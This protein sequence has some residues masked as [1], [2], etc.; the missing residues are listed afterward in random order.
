MLRLF[1]AASFV[2]ISL[3]TFSQTI[4]IAEARLLAEDT[5]VTVSG[6]VTNGSEL[7]LVR[8]F[9]DGTAGIAAFGPDLEDVLRGDSITITGALTEFFGLLE[10]VSISSILNHGPATLPIEPEVIS[11]D[12]LAENIE[13]ELVSIEL[14]SFS[15]GGAN[16]AGN[17]SYDFS[18]AN[19]TKSIYVREGHPLVGELVPVGPV[20]LT[21]LASQFS[22]SGFGGHQLILRDTSDIEN[23]NPINII[24]S[25]EISGQSNTGFTLSW[26]TDIESSSEA[27]FTDNIDGTEIEANQ[28]S[29]N[30]NSTNHTL[31]FTGLTPGE[32]YFVQ[33]F[34]VANGD[35]AFSNV[36]A[37]ATE[38]LSGNIDVYFNGSVNTSVAS[39]ES[40]E[41]I[42][43]NLRDT[44][45]AYIDRAQSSLDLAIYNTNNTEIVQAVNA[46]F[47]RGVEI[48]YIA[49]GQNANS[50]LGALLDEI[51][52]LVRQNS[53][54]SG[55]HNKF[56]LVD[57]ADEDS[58]YVLSGSTNFTDNNLSTDPN[59]LVIIQ[60]KAL[61]KSYRIEFNEMWGSNSP[62]SDPSASRFGE[63]KSNNTP[64]KFI[65]D[66]NPV[67]LYFSPSDGTNAAI[68]QALESADASIAF[69]LF[70]FTQNTLSDIIIEK[71][72]NDFIS[73]E[74]I[75]NDI[76]TNGSDFEEMVNQGV[77][78]IAHEIEFSLHHKYAIVDHDDFTSDPIVVTGSHNWSA[79]AGSV[80]DENTLVIH[81]AEIANQ[82]Y[83]EFT[84]RFGEV[85]STATRPEIELKLYPNPALDW[86][87]LEFEG[88]GNPATLSI[89]SLEGKVVDQLNIH[90]FNGS[91]GLVLDVSSLRAGIYLLQ[92]NEGNRTGMQ[93]L[94]ISK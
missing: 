19:G 78:V 51:P 73:V 55:M 58:S 62:V 34:S 17:E 10:I 4:S 38:S 42:Q 87:T 88:G 46:A 81:N 41:A 74:G 9:Q 65:I 5:E 90:A 69:A 2:A 80:N 82:F 21:G 36:A 66:G 94:A 22:F 91:N 35:T 48:R 47:E 28:L 8:Y 32:V 11:V 85:L 25:T 70:V 61:A 45:I 76:N 7:G 12:D 44:I 84:A 57:Y 3:V 50:A 14:V 20:N 93:R 26:S 56:V 86:I 67:E 27:F 33:V 39:S 68:A 89:Y 16:F 72:M 6:T 52:V 77:N 37:F 40:N 49:E 75:M 60:D 24:S 15:A 63:F 83:Q 29:V 59:N 18:S 54:G 71:S 92:Y 23:P 31:E 53:D 13:G 43:S 79:T 64:E 30:A 1:F